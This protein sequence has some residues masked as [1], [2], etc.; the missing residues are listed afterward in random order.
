MTSVVTPNLGFSPGNT[1]YRRV[2]FNSDGSL[3]PVMGACL[4]GKNPYKRAS[5]QL[6]DKQAYEVYFDGRIMVA[7]DPLKRPRANPFELSL[8][9]TRWLHGTQTALK[10]L[11]VLPDMLEHG[12]QGPYLTPTSDNGITVMRDYGYVELVKF[13]QVYFR[14]L[15]N[16]HQEEILEQVK[17]TKLWNCNIGED[18]YKPNRVISAAS[19]LLSLA[20]KEEVAISSHHPDPEFHFFVYYG[21]R[22]SDWVYLN[23]DNYEEFVDKHL[24]TIHR[25]IK[26]TVGRY[27]THAG[28]RGL[29]IQQYKV[30]LA[31]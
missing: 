23:A 31:S 10:T 22:R 21:E 19:D 5:Y 14:P 11:N 26:L 9:L 20:A 1:A 18:D 28:P 2:F 17:F 16:C 7:L 29:V 6:V 3:C 27:V 12:W 13:I 8:E 24:S 15:F 25:V 4:Y 30:A